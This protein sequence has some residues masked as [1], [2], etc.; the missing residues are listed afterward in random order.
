MIA[1]T[2]PTLSRHLRGDPVRGRLA[3]VALVAA[4]LVAV[5]GAASAEP[6]S[7]PLERS[8]Q[9]HLLIEGT[10]NGGPARWIV[11]TA[12]TGTALTATSVAALGLQPVRDAERTVHASGGSVRTSV[13]DVEAAGAGGRVLRRLRTVA[14]PEAVSVG[15]EVAGLLGIDW[16]RLS[17]PE[18]DFERGRLTLHERAT[19][20]D[21]RERLRAEG[22]VPVPFRPDRHGLLVFQVQVGDGTAYAVL[23]TG[24]DR[25][26][27][28]WPAA[29]L[30]GIVAGDPRLAA[31]DRIGG[32]TGHHVDSYSAPLGRLRASGSPAGL[33]PVEWVEVTA[34]VAD[35][36][37]YERLRGANLPTVTVGMDLLRQR[38][39]LVV[40][41]TGHRFWIR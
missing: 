11:D 3:A 38:R 36:P 10:L 27:F 32:A 2:R 18:F 24:A 15:T 17:M 6:V 39:G 30:A 31:A 34:L 7:L 37:V 25:S 12:A 5:A 14:L 4:L 19:A 41:F 33:P 28:N 26:V 21:V 40:D 9:G 22:Y 16:L 8:P 1:C 13:Y 35:M 23:D 20:A 29:A